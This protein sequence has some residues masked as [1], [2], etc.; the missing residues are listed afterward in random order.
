MKTSLTVVL[1]GLALVV[2]VNAGFMN[3]HGNGRGG[4]EMQERGNGNGNNGN[5][6]GWNHD[7][8]SGNGHRGGP[9][10]LPGDEH[11]K[12]GAGGPGGL[13]VDPGTNQVPDAG[14]MLAFIVLAAGGLSLLR[15]R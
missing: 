7:D 2:S 9:I 15:R 14:A 11:G 5:H 10:N 3:G 6:Y 8:F 4:P 12:R 13:C 1:L